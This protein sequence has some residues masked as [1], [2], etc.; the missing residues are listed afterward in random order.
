MNSKVSFC[1]ITVTLNAKEELEKTIKS[2]QSQSYKKFIHI[3]KDGLSNDKTNCID[4][5]KYKNTKFYESK[6]DGVY[7]A[8]NQ[9]FKFCENEYVIFLNAGDIFFSSNTLEDLAEN[10]R[11]HPNCNSYSGG[12]LQINPVTKKFQRLIGI[13]NLYKIFHLAQLPHPSFVV[14]R[15]VLSKLNNAFDPNLKISADYK[16]QLELR[17]KQLWKNCYLNEIISIMP[18]GGISTLNKKSII[19]GYKETFIFSFKLYKLTSIYI[20][21]VKLILNFYSR[22]E[23]SKLKNSNIKKYIFNNF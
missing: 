7:D 8:M 2:I 16:L 23:V 3:I 19:Y 12:T 10:I 1:I 5:F 11:N 20:I 18:T 15:S 14:R 9:G 21:L 4:F 17:K 6:D 22:L 13:G